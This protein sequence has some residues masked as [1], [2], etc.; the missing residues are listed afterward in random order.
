MDARDRQAGRG[1]FQW[2]KWA[3]RAIAPPLVLAL[4]G[5]A[6]GG[7]PARAREVRAGSPP[8]LIHYLSRARH[9]PG[10]VIVLAPGDYHLRALPYLDPT[11]GNC[12]DPA[13]SMPA[14]LGLR[15]SGE[16]VTIK[17][18][19]AGSARIHTHSGYGLLVEECEDC[20]LEGLTVTAGIR[21][22]AGLA[23]DAGIVVRHS[24]VTISRC[25]I[26]GNLGDSAVVAQTVS[27]IMGVCGREG[28]RIWLENTRIL[29]N[30][31]DGIALYR[32]AWARIEN[33]V[34]DGIDGGRPGPACG[35]RGVAVGVT[36]NARAE[37]VGNLI[38]RY[39]KGVGL[40]VD[41]EATVEGNI[42]EDM[43]TWGIALWD[44]GR[45]RPYGDIRGNFVYRT[46]ACGISVTRGLEGGRE[47]TRITGNAISLTGQNPK[48]D[49][50]EYYCTQEA[51]A[52]HATTPE[53]VLDSNWFCC[54]REAG[55][56]AGTR[57][58]SR[59]QFSSAT[60][61]LREELSLR[62]I[63]RES[64]ALREYPVGR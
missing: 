30:S 14:T 62:P 48:Y 24:S 5:G 40:F 46:G 44:A 39:W 47:N 22:T 9:E 52:V 33:C 28:S 3:T 26:S 32:D 51:L 42:I 35:G 7:Q 31:W 34:I 58:G 8:E 63:L 61:S 57:D 50:P 16:R 4:G 56:A 53:M 49:D 2:L 36:W 41:A 38:R 10:L 64:F 11:C 18:D 12:E 13:Q 54:N 60:Q 55:D 59:E 25:E 45:G 19:P 37:I 17:A 29:R 6:I 21:D 23:T 43:L 15:V 1:P 20:R 27:G